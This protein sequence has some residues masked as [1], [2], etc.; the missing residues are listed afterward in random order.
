M[1]V[2]QPNVA[3]FPGQTLA[4]LLSKN[5]LSQKDL[6]LKTGLT[7]KHISNIIQ[8]KASITEDTAIKLEYVFGGKASF[9]INLQKNYDED[10]ARLDFEEE[11][12]KELPLLKSFPIKELVTH[13][14]IS[15]VKEKSERLKELLKFFGVPSLKLV[16]KAQ[17]VAYRK[18]AVKGKKIDQN[19]VAAWLRIGEIKYLKITEKSDIPTY[20]ENAFK[21]GLLDIRRMTKQRNFFDKLSEVLL[22]NGVILIYS[23]YLH[24][25]FISGALRWIGGRPVVQ[26]NDHLKARDGLYFSLFHE[27][28]H[29]ILHDKRAEYVDYDDK[30]NKTDIEKEADSWACDVLINTVD[31]QKFLNQQDISWQSI[32][33][34]SEELEISKDIIIGRLAHD[35][36]IRWQDRAR[37]VGKVSYSS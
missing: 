29:M 1:L 14:F 21:K 17:A 13:N 20:D 4:R 23:P 11:L 31:Y 7:E 6:A 15:V 36:K 33:K 24:N 35:G 10:L 37:L 26:L 18:T 2:Y 22:K 30:S 5:S 27:F 9:W 8:G 34:F 25:T 32:A 16:I 28:G 12:N 3:I 19:A